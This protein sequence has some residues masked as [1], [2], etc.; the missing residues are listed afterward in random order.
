MQL[1]FDESEEMGR[2]RGL[3]IIPGRVVR[4]RRAD[5]PGTWEYGRS[6]K[7]PQIGWNQL[8]HSGTDP[9]LAGVPDG[10]YAYFV[11]SYYCTP[12]DPAHIVATTDFGINYASVVR[13]E[14]V[15][16]IQCHPEKSQRVGLW[17]LRNFVSIVKMPVTDT[18]TW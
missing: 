5:V 6:L 16:G 7:V 9:L 17:I 3:G 4:F 12:A 15:W 14:R 2:H 1:L 8:H 10:A 13:R 18:V 11:H